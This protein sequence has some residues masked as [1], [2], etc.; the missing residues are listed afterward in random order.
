MNH[1]CCTFV[2][3]FGF[4]AC[5]C[6][7][8]N[9]AKRSRGP[10][11]SNK[12]NNACFISSAFHFKLVSFPLFIASRRFSLNISNGLRYCYAFRLRCLAFFF[13]SLSICTTVYFIFCHFY[14][15]REM[16]VHLFSLVS[17]VQCYIAHFN[18]HLL[19]A[20]GTAFGVASLWFC[21]SFSFSVFFF[22]VL[23]CFRFQRNR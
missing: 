6:H 14:C 3:V 7:V 8:F 12:N 22:I 23:F 4:F 21:I 19:S 20:T 16:V 10:F 17:F 1:C 13:L 9:K 5:V 18:S 2:L 15:S 11:A